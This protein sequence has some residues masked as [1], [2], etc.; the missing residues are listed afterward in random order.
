MKYL[1]GTNTICLTYKELVPKIISEDNFRQLKKRGEGRVGGMR[2]HG[3]NGP[4][5]ECLIE[6]ESLRPQDKALVVKH[7]G[8]PKDYIATEPLK[9]LVTVDTK[10]LQWYA[11]YNLNQGGKE[12]FL[13]LA[14]QL[15]Y[16][17]Q[18]D[19][20]GA[21]HKLM[22]N[23]KATKDILNISILQLWANFSM[24]INNDEWCNVTTLDGKQLHHELPTSIDRLQRRYWLYRDKG[25]EG[26]VEA[27]R[28]GNDHNRKVTPKIENLILSLAAQP[29]K[30]YNSEIC[31]EYRKFMT[32][33]KQIVD[34]ETGEV[35]D[36]KD[37]Y[38]IAPK[39]G[40]VK[41]K[42][43]KLLL[44]IPYA[45]AESTVDYYIKK[46]GNQAIINKGRM[47]Q[48][49]YNTMY[50]PSVKRLAPSYAFSKITM[51][52]LDIPFKDHEGQRSV[53]SY[54][55]FDV[56]SGAVIGVS[57]SRDKNIDLIREA[58]RDMYRLIIRNNWG[59]PF[60]IEFE[61]HLT[62][63]MTGG[64]DQDGKIYEDVLT[65]GT[66]FPATRMCIGGNAKEK[67]A[68]GF[69]RVKKYGQQKKRP[70]FQARFYARLLTNRLNSDQDKTRYSYEEIVN[71]ELADI[72]AH[73]SELHPKQDLY[74]GLTRWDVLVQN[75]NPNLPQYKPHQV[76]QYIGYSTTTSIRAG[77]ARV[78]YGDYQLPD[79]NLIQDTKYN[80][81]IVAYYLPDENG[82]VNSV[83]LFED[84]HFL[85]EAKEKVGFQEAIAEQGAHDIAIMQEQ[86]GQQSA[87]DAMVRK[88]KQRITPVG[89]VKP[90]A[91]PPARKGV[92]KQMATP[93]QD[94]FYLPEPEMN[95]KQRALRDI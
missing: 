85:C 77:V 10:A 14:Y 54:Q 94:N 2:V 48:L 39:Q 37:F 55:I 1:P 32:G 3:R 60:E 95:T 8:E 11:T 28:F 59:M 69:I 26:L 44:T 50:R 87:F 91:L 79:I 78:S 21:I 40:K 81:E 31:I 86:F 89:T 19:W 62:S 42:D 9:E 17:R 71:N 53:K 82:M 35:F 30:P 56:C 90:A 45:L 12:K 23:K 29:H 70:G 6:Y 34:L 15:K 43:K 64:V 61:K 76:I 72:A 5:T 46:P 92:V 7:Y 13:P 49:D 63:N 58:I 88:G 73:N 66:V 47:K 65:A 52:D 74:P 4:Y 38:I 16:A 84:G 20:L 57:F 41:N 24:L 80:G 22:V 75:Q 93:V 27:W 83:F 51:D 36:P 33:D 68:E 25:Y 18:C 67:R